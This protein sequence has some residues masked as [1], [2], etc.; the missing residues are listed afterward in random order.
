MLNISQNVYINCCQW[1]SDWP[2]GMQKQP[3]LYR[4]LP[5]AHCHLNTCACEAIC[6]TGK[7]SFTL[8]EC[9]VMNESQKW[10]WKQFKFRW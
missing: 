3:W 10:V 2:N 1:T 7:T 5:L 6:T 8:N 9:D 4:L